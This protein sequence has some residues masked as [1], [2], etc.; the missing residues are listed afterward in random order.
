MSKKDIDKGSLPVHIGIIM[1]GNGRWAKQRGLLR[2][3]GHVKGAQNFRT[4]ANYCGEIGIKY[5]TVYAFST[6]NWSRP[7]YEIDALM[8]LFDDYLNEFLVDFRKY[9]MK[10]NFIGNTEALT[11]SIIQKM[12]KA[13]DITKNSTGIT[14]N[15][16]INYGGRQEIINA[17]KKIIK[18]Q[19]DGVINIDD[20]DEKLFSRFLYTHDQPDPDLIIRPS[21]EKRISNFLIWQSAYTEFWYS[22]VLWPDFTKSDLDKALEDYSKRNRRFGGI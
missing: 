10:L 14:V 5:I 17:V 9:N 1:D 7:K 22:D 12:N 8:K 19:N 11:D 2:T 13:M 3:A 18:K 20:I 16:A 15:I 4:I 6:E 21:G